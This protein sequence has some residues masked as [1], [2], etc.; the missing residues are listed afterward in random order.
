MMESFHPY[1]VLL[2]ILIV[3]ASS[4]ALYWIYTLLTNLYQDFMHFSR[5]FRGVE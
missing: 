5:R 1:V 4:L 2:G 3:A